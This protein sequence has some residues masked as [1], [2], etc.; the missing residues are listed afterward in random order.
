MLAL[1]ERRSSAVRQDE[2]M[3]VLLAGASGFLGTALRHE[4]VD[5]GHDVVQLI[6][7]QRRGRN[8]T[9]PVGADQASWDP[10][11]RYVP[12]DP[13]RD[14]DVVINLAGAPIAHWPWTASYKKTLLESRTSTTRTLAEGIAGL[15]RKPALINASA[16]G[17]YGPDRGD[18]LLDETSAPGDGFF[19]ELTQQWEAAAGPAQE[20]GGRVVFTR[21]AVVLDGRG[22]ALQLM[23]LPFLAGVGGKIGNGAQ[24]FATV[25]L[26]DYVGVVVR[27][28]TDA[29]TS[30]VYNITAPQP[31]TNAEFTKALGRRLHRP[32]FLRVPK[33]PLEKLVGEPAEE[34]LGSLR[35]R[36]ARLLD[37]GFEFADPDIDSQLATALR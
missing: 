14:A 12:L 8:Q 21:N 23:R 30:G 37:A 3:R 18:E 17:Y 10:Y 22:G 27:L 26:R 36:P 9:R 5:G 24:W 20:A 2:D 33:L 16:V 7:S 31:A 11:R 1:R 19:A 34:I 29:T 6:R 15:D 13:L 28:T 35:V 25:S 32:T 4:L